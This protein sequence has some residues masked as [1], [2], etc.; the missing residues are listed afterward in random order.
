MIKDGIVLDRTEGLYCWD[1]EANDTSTQ[2]E[3]CTPPSLG[4]ARRRSWRLC[5]SRWNGRCS[6]PRFTESPRPAR[7]HR[8]DRIDHARDLRF[9]KTYSGGSEANESALNLPASISNRPG[10]PTSINSSAPNEFH[11]AP[12]RRERKRRGAAQDEFEPEV[13]GFLKVPNPIHFAIPF[14]PGRRRTVS[15]QTG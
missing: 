1:T 5:G 10:F 4:I 2:S 6:F 7:I 8:E 14:P 3:A 9:I 15:A 11:G 12:C 13:A